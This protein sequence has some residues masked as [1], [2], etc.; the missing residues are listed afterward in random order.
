MAALLVTQGSMV[1]HSPLFISPRLLFHDAPQ[2]SKSLL[3]SLLQRLHPPLLLCVE[4]PDLRGQKT[5]KKKQFTNNNDKKLT[6][7][8]LI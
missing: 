2:I 1:R 6:T 8:P 3:I 5:N 7:A 4:L